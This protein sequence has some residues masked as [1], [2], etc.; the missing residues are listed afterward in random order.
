MKKALFA[1]A[2]MGT[3]A[4]AAQA[5]SSITLYGIIDVALVYTS[6]SGGSKLYSLNAGNVQA[7]RWGL[8]GTED[9]GGGLK[10]LFVLENGFAATTGRLQQ[11][12]DEFGRQAYVGLS[13]AKLGSLTLGRQYDSAV[14]FVGPTIAG[15]Q[16]ATYY[17]GHPGDLDNMTNANR[18]N[19]AIKYTSVNYGGFKFG[20]LYSLGGVAGQFTRNQIWSVG[21]G[22]AR[23]P[24]TLAAGYVNVRDPNYSF[25]GNNAASSTN[26]SNM[27][28][29]RVYSGYASAKTQQIFAASG[30]YAFGAATVGAVYTNTQFNN[31]GSEPGL[32]PLKYSGS[33]KF[34]NAEVNFKY[35]VTPTVLVGTAFDYTKGYGVNNPIYRQVVAGVDYFLSKRTDVFVD[36]MYQHASGTDSSGQPAVANFDGQTPSS[37]ANQLVAVVGYRHKF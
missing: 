36:V 37:N 32:N 15:T 20:G 11:G 25:F 12:N 17:A 28:G 10:A 35:L 6:N 29:S 26:G 21:A 24:L 19:N 30:T 9:L 23:G 3:F 27:G 33:A 8:R 13:D 2:A 14:D 31:L 7:N 18:V 34:H 5:Q 22:F 16:W 1:A 4:G